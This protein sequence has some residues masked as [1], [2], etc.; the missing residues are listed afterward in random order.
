M[1]VEHELVKPKK[2]EK[3]MY[4]VNIAEAASNHST[5]VVLPTGMGKTI[6][7]MLVITDILKRKKGRVLFLAPT[8]PLV[9][10]HAS[11]LR[12]FLVDCEPMV[13]TGETQPKKRAE[14]W[15]DAQIIVSTPQVVV[16]D[17][18]SAR[19]RLTDFGLIIYD[20][21]HRA[22]GD[23]AY[24]FIAEKYRWV[25]GLSLGMTASPGSEAKKILD[26]CQNL[27]I[28]RVE[29]RSEYDPDV[30]PYVHEI[31]V[32]WIRVP[33]PA[34]FLEITTL[35]R[36][37]FNEYIKELKKFGFFRGSKPVSM[38]DLLKVQREI[39]ARIR[40]GSGKQS[41]YYS[42]ASAQAAAVKVNHALEL[43][44]TQG[45]TA[46][47]NY[48]ERLGKEAFSRGASRA[49]KSIMNHPNIKEVFK[50]LE[51]INIDLLQ[52]HQF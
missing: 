37:I 6:V 38:K 41:A 17:L 12:E 51:K 4:Q 8:K 33:V 52:I 21:A 26:V 18:I 45:I 34:R 14:L 16:N 25:N 5:L 13:F 40:E 28:E 24:V 29:I 11:F 3:R 27:G 23:Y 22:V 7:A 31:K 49:S 39:Q 20:E 44:E 9:E 32:R 35:L 48:L 15:K 2:I 47:K 10:Q 50:V 36:K 43:V 19:T 42:A 46:L 1:F 30:M